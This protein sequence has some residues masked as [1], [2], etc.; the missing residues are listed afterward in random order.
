MVADSANNLYVTGNFGGT[1]TYGAGDPNQTS[2]TSAGGADIFVAKYNSSGVIQWA[3][4]AG[5]LLADHP[6]A[7]L[8]ELDGYVLRRA[9]AMLAKVGV[10]EFNRLLD[11][12][13]P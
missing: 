10:I 8:E 2:L 11:Q 1:E 7:H 6:E 5:R 3:K 4:R 9:K 12:V 13:T